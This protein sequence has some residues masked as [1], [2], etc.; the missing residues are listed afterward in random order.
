MVRSV[1]DTDGSP[2]RGEAHQEDREWTAEIVARRS[3]GSFLVARLV[4]A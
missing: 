4:A 3:H 2:Y 1:L